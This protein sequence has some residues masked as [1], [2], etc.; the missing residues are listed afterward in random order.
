MC[1]K[2]SVI[3]IT[4]NNEHEIGTCLES[5]KWADEMVVLDSYSDDRTEQICKGYGA[6]FYQGPFEGYSTQLNRCLDLAS[7]EW[8][9]N[10][11]ADEVITAE[12]RDEIQAVLRGEVRRVCDGYTCH[13]HQYLHAHLIKHSGW[14]PHPELRFFRKARARF[15]SREPHQK[16]DV[17]GRV[18]R[19]K[20]G[21]LH[22]SW[23]NNG[24]IFDNFMEYAKT[25]ARWA[26]EHEGRRITW[27]NFLELP[28]EFWRRFI[29]RGG[30]FHGTFGIIM[31]LR[32]SAY[33][34]VKYTLMWELQNQDKLDRG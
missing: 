9:L 12:L 31:S 5:V 18:G 27:I 21:L 26:Y 24:E 15:R 8:I 1:D 34:Y 33:R 20:G 6:Q 25:E 14:Y 30:M 4:K 2:V 19:L 32:M 10:V 22:R 13:R 28:Y 23:V 3:I 11:Y 7:N 16:V 29:L 17:R